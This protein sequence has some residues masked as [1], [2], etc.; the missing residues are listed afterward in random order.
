M[1]DR[2]RKLRAKQKKDGVM[3]R[4]DLAANLP[5]HFHGEI[6]SFSK[7]EG[8]SPWE[9]LNFYSP[10]PETDKRPADAVEDVCHYLGVRTTAKGNV[11]SSS[12][13]EIFK[14]GEGLKSARAVA[15]MCHFHKV[16]DSKLL[17]DVPVLEPD[18]EE[19]SRT[20]DSAVNRSDLNKAF[21]PDTVLPMEVQRNVTTRLRLANVVAGRIPVTGDGGTVPI[22]KTVTD[23]EGQGT[24]GGKVPRYNVEFDSEPLTLTEDGFEVAINDQ[25]RRSSAATI[26]GIAESIRQRTE[27]FEQRI[28]NGIVN[29]I[30]TGIGSDHTFSWSANPSGEDLME[31]HMVL[32]DNYILRTFVGTLKGC[33]SYLAIDP[34]YTSDVQRPATPDLRR[35]LAVDAMLGRE[36]IVKRKVEQVP[37]LGT[38][39]NAKKLG[40]W[41][42][43]N[44]FNFYTERGGS[45]N[46][47]YREERD[48]IQVMRFVISYG[49][50]KRAEIDNCRVFI[51]MA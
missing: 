47:S 26:G 9:G 24:A 21:N 2:I 45:L 46:D 41:D 11:P 23:V 49:G 35:T 30:L 12:T 51:N 28:T 50:R 34:T 16:F 38:D 8:I 33:V 13:E 7:E 48:R 43:Q 27:F 14:P 15:T 40:A 1:S 20:L 5:K 10:T 18:G 6:D 31:L 44:A 37:A 39:N 32:D 25:T 4:R 19:M 3:S 36:S 29:E 22:L 17:G 42:R